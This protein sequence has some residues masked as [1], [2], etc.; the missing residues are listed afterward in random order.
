MLWSFLGWY[1]AIHIKVKG[2]PGVAGLLSPMPSLGVSRPRG[3]RTI[4]EPSRLSEA[5]VPPCRG[6]HTETV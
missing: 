4:S 1:R 5:L 6:I 2:S 3:R